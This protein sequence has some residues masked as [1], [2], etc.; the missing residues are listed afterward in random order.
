MDLYA[1]IVRRFLYPLWIVKN[2]SKLL[3]YLE[4]FERTQYLAQDLIGAI[5]W[6]QF[7]AVLAHAYSTCEFYTKRFD[8]IG[9]KP[10]D[11]RCPD[12]IAKIPLTTKQDVQEEGE[13]MISTQYRRD[14]LVRD[15]TGGSTGAPL[16]FH[17][18]KRR[19]ESRNAAMIRHNR[20]VGWDI[21]DK[22]A[23]LWGA[24]QDTRVYAGFKRKLR[25]HLLERQL[26]LDASSFSEDTFAGFAKKLVEFQPK[27]ILGYANMIVEFA[28]YV[29]QAGI[30]GIKLHAIISSAE[31]LAPESRKPIE[32]TFGCPVFNRYG[33]REFSVIASECHYRTGMHINAEN[34][35]VEVLQNGFSG[36]HGEGELVIT[37]L[38]NYGMP[39]IRYQARDVGAFLPGMC[40]CGRG[41]PLMTIT[42]GRVSDFLRSTNGRR[43][44]GLVISQYVITNIPGIKQVQFVQREQRRTTIR[45]VKGQGWDSNSMKALR[46]RVHH[47]LGYDMELEFVFQDSVPSEVSGKY[48]FS[49]VSID[50]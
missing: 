50:S 30:A 5:Q 37:D 22:S 40:E 34:L 15:M 6:T 42:G 16:V 45:L 49:I 14:L 10:E 46:S 41:L 24:P 32:D 35:L 21:G 33:A 13:Q 4:E 9:M 43:V 11:I 47:Y 44:S 1:E 25:Y 36:Q 26:I 17:Y 2:R 23:A 8:A 48:R 28:R 12:D 27:V 7:K 29:R 20:W 38:K 31:V 3:E 18:D 39:L 19:L